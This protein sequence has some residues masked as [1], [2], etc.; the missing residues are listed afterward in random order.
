MKTIGIELKI[1]IGIDGFEE[2]SKE[3]QYKILS[4]LQDEITKF[5]DNGTTMRIVGG[6]GKWLKGEVTKEG[7]IRVL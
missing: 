6:E 5:I 1:K 2:L 3:E 7:Y 4:D